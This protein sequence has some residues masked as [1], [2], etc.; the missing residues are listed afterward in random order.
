MKKMSKNSKVSY[1]M[2][3]WCLYQRATDSCKVFVGVFGFTTYASVISAG[4]ESGISFWKGT[5]NNR[6]WYRQTSS[7]LQ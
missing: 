5:S 7:S 3:T 1:N 4:E 6:D 2:F